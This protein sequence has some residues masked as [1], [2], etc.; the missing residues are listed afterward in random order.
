MIILLTVVLSI[1]GSKS[2]A[3]DPYGVSAPSGKRWVVT[4]EDDFTKDREI[5]EK[6][7][8]SDASY[9]KCYTCL[10][11]LSRMLK[12][13]SSELRMSCRQKAVPMLHLLRAQKCN[14]VTRAPRSL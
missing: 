14:I 7:S 1:L 2:Y 6:R 11:E 10:T 5:D 3:A 9:Y 13:A 12:V 4:F 8:Y